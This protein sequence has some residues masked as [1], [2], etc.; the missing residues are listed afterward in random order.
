VAHALE[1]SED[2]RQAIALRLSGRLGHFSNLA[3][4]GLEVGE[5]F[6]THILRR[7][8]LAGRRRIRRVQPSAGLSVYV[9]VQ[10]RLA[11]KPVL[12][13]HVKA[14]ANR[15]EALNVFGEHMAPVIGRA[16]LWADDHAP[17]AGVARILLLPEPR[18]VALWIETPKQDRILPV[19]GSGAP[20]RLRTDQTYS[21][22]HFFKAAF[23][24]YGEDD[25]AC[26]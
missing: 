11:G 7:R 2:H 26:V 1:L 16:I 3:A 25:L 22:H 21:P 17:S 18:V 19:L 23:G 9:H 8:D 24:S 12:C 5:T 20:R 13:A 6:E 15:W 14:E 10:I 4:R